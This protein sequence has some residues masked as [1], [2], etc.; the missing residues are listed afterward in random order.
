MFHQTLDYLWGK[1]H[2]SGSSEGY[3]QEWEKEN[4][5]ASAAK[6]SD[7]SQTRI[8]FLGK[9]RRAKSPLSENWYQCEHLPVRLVIRYQKSMEVLS[10]G[11]V[12]TQNLA[13]SS[14]SCPGFSCRM[15]LSTP[16]LVVWRKRGV[17]E[18]KESLSL[19]PFVASSS[20]LLT[21]SRTLPLLLDAARA[22]KKQ[23]QRHLLQDSCPSAAGPMH[24]PLERR[25]YLSD[26][27]R[28]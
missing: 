26:L 21:A 1:G 14:I 16:W 18:G 20:R 4:V 19:L 5:R 28:S 10:L 22:R 9:W 7:S 17:N 24:A 2:C 15:W 6:P 3:C 11:V 8:R 25:D 13:S 12:H 27:L 23:G